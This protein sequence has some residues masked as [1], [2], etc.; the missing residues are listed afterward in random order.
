MALGRVV[1]QR[2]HVAHTMK[3]LSALERFN[4]LGIVVERSESWP[5]CPPGI[6][7]N[8]PW[9]HLGEALSRAL[10]RAKSGGRGASSLGQTRNS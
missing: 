2:C 8:P 7:S 9:S 10:R 6:V 3:A 1:D 4:R 5:A